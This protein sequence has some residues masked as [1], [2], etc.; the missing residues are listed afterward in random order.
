[1]NP[2]ESVNESLRWAYEKSFFYRQMYDKQG[3]LIK[4]SLTRADFEQ[5]PIISLLEYISVP[6]LDVL[7]LPLSAVS[8]IS[9]ATYGRSRFLKARSGREISESIELTKN[10][11]IS[12]GVNRT[13][14]A[15]LD[16]FS[17]AEGTELSM[18][19][20]AIGAGIYHLPTEIG[21][22]EKLALLGQVGIDTMIVPVNALR[23]YMTRECAAILSRLFRIITI[24]CD[25]PKD[26]KQKRISEYEATLGTPIYE[27][28]S[29]PWTGSLIDLYRNI[30]S[31]DYTARDT[32]LIDKTANGPIVTDTAARAMPL[33]RVKQDG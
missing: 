20:S 30:N 28:I 11:L 13:S 33:I 1:M 24:S 3:M 16:G 31:D 2:F 23:E 25:Y 9:S 12:T 5:L 14:V 15:A 6:F 18:A 32:L 7:S 17:A 22:A 8:E 10:Y 21:F 4:D 29:L 19:L 26:E 27:I